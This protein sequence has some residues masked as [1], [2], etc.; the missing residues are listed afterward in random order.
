MT[1]SLRRAMRTLAGTVAAALAAAALA[2]VPVQ[3]EIA[4]GFEASPAVAA[5]RF[6]AVTANPHATEAALDMLREGGTAVDAAVAA[7]MVL[8]V[9]EPQSSG[10]GGGG[11]LVHYDARLDRVR[12]YDGREAAPARV[13]EDLFL[14]PDGDPMAFYDA[15]VGGRSVGVPGLLRMLELAHLKHGRLEW[16]RLFAPAVRLAEQGFA[17]SPR[18]HALIAAD[19]HLRADPEARALFYDA[20]GAP[21]AVGATLR[22]PALA[23][24]LRAVARGGAQ[25]FYEGEIARD[26]VSAVRRHANP[27][28]LHAIDLADYRAIERE[29]LCGTYRRYR[30]CGAPPPSSGPATVLAMLGMVERFDLPQVAP[31]SAFAAHL[32]A[33]AGSLA[34]ADRDTYPS[35]PVAMPLAPAVLLSRDYLR[36]RSGEIDLRH[37]RGRAA[38]G[39]PTAAAAGASSAVSPERSSTTHLSIVDRWGNAI[40]LTASI[41]DAF[42]ARLM[43][44]GF[45]L[46]NQL[47]DF[48]FRPAD[49]HGP[50]PNR[51][52]PG[53]RPRSSMSPLVVFAPD[54]RLHAV[55]GSPGGSHIINF[56][57]RTLVGLLDWQLA[58]DAVLAMPNF[59]SRNGPVDVEDSPA[60]G[61]LADGL[62]AFGHA[63]RLRALT[64]GL[65]VI[66]RG[67]DGW[68]GAA[69]PRR[70][71]RAAG[72]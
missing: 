19:R 46:N 53:K 26:M 43:V 23:E 52:G 15:V 41:E 70:E 36:S 18:L 24:V 1:A 49:A 65:H 37:S 29:A 50:L 67:A 6:M 64:S 3:P 60:G 48:S 21:L 58:P 34:F 13:Q 2:Q 30:I 68:L 55:L 42:G 63:A 8:N 66:V 10:I 39:A 4:S 38:P 28:E 32:L 44:D 56:V 14:K 45:L 27:G 51:V 22:N 7:A 40:S 12:S 54:G 69:D 35:D 17:V 20:D 11:F 59:G 71:G 25:V 61:Q 47:T 57:A 9:V 5:R 33:E 16:E 31:G 72:D 62:A